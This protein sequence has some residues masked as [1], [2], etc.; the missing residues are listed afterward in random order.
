MITNIN[1]DYIREIC[2]MLRKE[3]YAFEPDDQ[4]SFDSGMVRKKDNMPIMCTIC[5][6]YWDWDLGMPIVDLYSV[7]FHSYFA[8][9]IGLDTLE[10]MNKD[11]LPAL[12]T[13]VRDY[14]LDSLNRPLREQGLVNALAGSDELW[15]DEYNHVFY[16][17]TDINDLNDQQLGRLVH[18]VEKRLGKKL[19]SPIEVAVDF[20]APKGVTVSGRN[21]PS[22]KTVVSSV[23]RK[24]S[25][26]VSLK[27]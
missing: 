26:G 18:D 27:N 5:S 4:I 19:Y 15:A 20:S 9:S 8:S 12:R 3:G 11:C 22:V 21:L 24:D 25:T 23:V 7:P 13:K 2:S 1:N 10:H 16:H 14:F 6:I 17:N